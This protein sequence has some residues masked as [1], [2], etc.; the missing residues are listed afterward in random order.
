MTARYPLAGLLKAARR[1]VKGVDRERV[2]ES[3][4]RVRGSAY[5]GGGITNAAMRD[6]CDAVAAF[7]KPKEPGHDPA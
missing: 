1:V 4:A 2:A 5:G 7:D 6:L 3:A